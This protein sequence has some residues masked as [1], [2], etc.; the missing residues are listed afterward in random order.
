MNIGF[1][2]TFLSLAIS[3]I[4]ALYLYSIPKPDRFESRIALQNFIAFYV[5]AF[6]ATGMFFITVMQNSNAGAF[7]AGLINSS[8][9]LLSCYSL[10]FGVR[11]LYTKPVFVLKSPLALAHSVI[12]GTGLAA[13]ITLTEQT[14]YAPMRG[15]LYLNICAILFLAVFSFFRYMP[16]DGKRYRLFLASLITTTLAYLVTL[17]IDQI[18]REPIV[19]GFT[20]VI[21]QNLGFVAM[22]GGIYTLYIFNLIEQRE[23]QALTDPMT[24]L[25]NRRVL[26]EKLGQHVNVLERDKR[27]MCMIVM[28]IDL[29]KT[30]NDS[31][32]HD[33][34]DQVIQR[35]AQTITDSIR[36][37]D[38]AI[39]SGGDEFI[40]ILPAVTLLDAESC[41]QRIHAKLEDIQVPSENSWV[42][43]AATFGVAGPATDFDSLFK[44]SDAMLYQAK[45][46]GRNRVMTE[47]IG[48]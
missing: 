41:A 24:G 21:A 23:Q 36:D 4:C 48:I 29:F 1:F 38:L 39:R 45:E 35:V 16:R 40:I 13:W 25:Y 43:V 34:G 9:I 15:I 26:E 7:V 37:I 2:S 3:L 27:H 5:L 32:G 46:A 28:D 30:I 18:A 14:D 6:L 12:I 31:H 17:I 42:R 11:S 8:L 44:R 47:I 10:Y 20:F 22:F 19:Y 33:I